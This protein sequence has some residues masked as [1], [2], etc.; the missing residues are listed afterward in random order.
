MLS[1]T[2][3]FGHFDPL[4]F[5]RY[6]E[7]LEIATLF[8]FSCNPSSMIRFKLGLHGIIIFLNCNCANKN[9]SN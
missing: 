8:I 4:L 1:S 9:F 2:L 3:L 7:R 5:L 6:I